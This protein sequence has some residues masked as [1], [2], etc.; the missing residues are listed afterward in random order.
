MRV[1]GVDLAAAPKST[2]VV[3]LE[4]IDETNWRAVH[5]PGPPTDDTLVSAARTVDII[6]VD[7]PLGWPR[8][9]VEAVDAHN[10]FRP[11]P[12][13]TD[14]STLTHRDTDRAIRRHGIR[15]AL[16]V[17]ADKLGSV[18][19]RCA[20]LQR[21][22]AEVWG[23]PAPRDGSGRLVETYPAAALT[24]WQVGY[25]GYKDRRD[26]PAARTVREQI[27]RDVGA[28]VS[29]WLDLAGV[30]EPCV[31]SDHVLD[32]LVSGLVAIAAASGALPLLNPDPRV[33][34]S[35]SRIDGREAGPPR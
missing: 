21:R 16:S 19:M 7:S 14:R 11:W 25:A 20:L 26:L 34:R 33:A 8:A 12:G 23:Q 2:G 1:M 27:I 5:L 6:G 30:H 9:F 29:A 10:S 31:E 3:V 18:G 28:A 4:A 17:S 22:W 32:A 13:G 35:S 24:A 15:A